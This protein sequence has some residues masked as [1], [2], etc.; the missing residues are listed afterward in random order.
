MLKSQ[1]YY[2]KFCF[3][4][5]N[6]QSS[7]QPKPPYIS[8]NHHFVFSSTI[9]F[10]SIPTHGPSRLTPAG[11]TFGWWSM[12]SCPCG[13]VSTRKPVPKIFSYPR[14]TGDSATCGRSTC[15][16][17]L[18]IWLGPWFRCPMWPS[19]TRC[20]GCRRCPPRWLI[21]CKVSI[22]LVVWWFIVMLYE[23]AIYFKLFTANYTATAG[24]S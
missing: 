20:P 24:K 19:C 11:A 21:L 2:Q 18:E 4:K 9:Y 8:T 12:D 6:G 17:R 10:S 1:N 5:I 14:T 16:A 23:Y 3:H 13:S 15:A 7:I 22:R